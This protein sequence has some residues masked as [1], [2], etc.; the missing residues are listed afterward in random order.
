MGTT[1]ATPQLWR[2]DQHQHPYQ[3]PY[4]HRYQRRR[5]RGQRLVLAVTLIC[6]I[7]AAGL[8][9]A[10]GMLLGTEPSVPMSAGHD[11]HHSH[12]DGVA[13]MPGMPGMPGM[14]GTDARSGA[15][16][17]AQPDDNDAPHNPARAA[18]SH[19]DG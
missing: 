13:G 12:D 5:Q 19:E 14:G 10:L 15:R 9:A 4:Q 7:A 17:P 3:H 18:H 8:T 16:A 6:G 11:V 1:E 2:R